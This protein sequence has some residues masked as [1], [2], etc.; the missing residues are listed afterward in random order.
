MITNVARHMGELGVKYQ[1]D[2]LLSAYCQDTAAN[3]DHASGQVY[4]ALKT[5]YTVAELEALQLWD[6]LAEKA[7]ATNFC[8]SA[9]HQPLPPKAPPTVLAVAR[10]SGG[11]R[12]GREAAMRAKPISA[13]A[14]LARTSALETNGIVLGGLQGAQGCI[15]ASHPNALNHCCKV[16][17]KQ[18]ALT[19]R[20][21]PCL[22]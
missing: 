15:L 17:G 2:Y 11:H 21:I 16:T 22:F 20:P 3:L 18:G 19:P 6:K 14:S 1:S 8:A 5:Y 10:P 12:R 7:A 9:A 4:A 13:S